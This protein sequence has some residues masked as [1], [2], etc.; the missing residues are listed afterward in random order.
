MKACLGNEESGKY[1]A[2]EKLLADQGK[3]HQW[4]DTLERHGLRISALATHGEPRSPNKEVAEAYSRR[5]RQ[6]C[7]LAEAAGVDRLTTNGGVPEA[8][9]GET[10]PFWV[11]ESSKPYHRGI[12]RWQWEQ[13]VIPF[14]REHAKIAQDHGCQLCI[15]PWIGEIIYS[16]TTVM[17]LR[18]AMG[19]VI[20]C[21]LDPSH[22]FPQQI[23]V[24]ESILF[25]L[26]QGNV[27]RRH[28]IP[29]GHYWESFGRAQQHSRKVRRRDYEEVKPGAQAIYR[30][31]SRGQARQAFYHFRRRWRDDYPTMVRQLEKGLPELLS[32]F[33]FPRHPWPKLRTTNVIERLFVEVRRRTGRWS[34]W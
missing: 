8:A 17:K 5:F 24:I 2:F 7:Q 4:L 1:C 19:T 14:W 12:L 31:A 26:P 6:V 21:N 23:D 27:W 25:L 18:D 16:P 20:G 10:Y 33:S 32:F 9:P 34:A 30:A 28:G 3:L 13:R 29:N 11:A 15:E 22:F